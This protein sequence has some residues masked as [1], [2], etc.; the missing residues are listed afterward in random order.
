M[1]DTL[2]QSS[3]SGHPRCLLVKP[4]QRSR[5][6][7]DTARNVLALFIFA[8]ALYTIHGFLP[9]L[10]WGGVF[11]IA[12]WPLYT[13]ART[14]WPEAGSGTVLPFLFTAAM[15]LI[16]VIP[17][18]L[19]TLEAVGEAQSALSWLE[20]ARRS[21]VP[22]PDAVTH[23]P[24]VSETLTKW[25]QTHLSNAEDV[26]SLTG[27]LD[28]KG[29]AI[30]KALGSQIAHRGTL[31]CFSIITLFFLYKDGTSVIRQCRVASRRAFGKRG[32]TI[33]RQII[34]SVHGTVL[35]LVLVGIAE[36]VLMGIVYTF[37][38]APHPALFGVIT[39]VAAMIPFCAM[40]AVG[41]V[42]LLILMKGAS[43]AA[44]VTFGIGAVIIFVADHF[45]RP[46]LIGGSTQL[47]FLW[48]LLG[49]LGG[50]ETWG[51]LGLFVG[52]AVMAALN[53]LWRRWTA[54]ENGV[55]A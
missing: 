32:E 45:I 3:A 7:Q 28:S 9:A 37:A 22:V 15:V 44:I 11:A 55:A 2:S 49:I 53:L 4:S 8:L 51:L 24:F 23:L 10:V 5:K 39:A 41:L 54:G 19:I 20:E 18:M 13:R 14:A 16:F 17:L 34:A 50:A 52:P 30:T 46:V 29:M 27:A 36:G 48:V 21:G 1:P 38:G 26:S 40:I 43:L 6:G 31:F 25:W 33:A 12:T 42:S 47:P 35:G